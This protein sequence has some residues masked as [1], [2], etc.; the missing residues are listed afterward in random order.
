MDEVI[1]TGVY[2][3]W[4]TSTAGEHPVETYDLDKS[5]EI[6]RVLRE[7]CHRTRGIS[8]DHRWM[9]FLVLGRRFALS[10]LNEGIGPTEHVRAYGPDW[11]LS[12]RRLQDTPADPLIHVRNPDAMER[13]VAMMLL[14]E[15]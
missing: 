12:F 15:E 7:A 6:A 2:D 8:P 10:D 11:T 14:I 13:D 9:S 5:V 3:V 1:D 4:N